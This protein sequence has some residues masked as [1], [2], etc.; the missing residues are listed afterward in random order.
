MEAA[1][2]AVG[3]E[4]TPDRLALGV[5]AGAV[6]VGGS[7][8]VAVRFSNRELDPLWGAFLRFGLAAAVFALLVAVLRLPLP[9][10][11]VLGPA[12]VYGVLAF[13]GTYGCLY[14]ALRRAA[15]REHAVDGGG[16]ED[17]A[18]RER[19]RRDEEGEER[20]RGESGGTRPRADR[21]RGC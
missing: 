13:G 1:S 16:A 14:W 12:A 19:Q 11:R 7:N 6:V 5:F 8:F 10:R 9:S 21:A 2:R 3:A 20:L 17:A 15:E 4:H 18:A